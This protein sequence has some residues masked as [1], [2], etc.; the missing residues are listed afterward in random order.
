MILGLIIFVIFGQ[1]LAHVGSRITKKAVEKVSEV[2]A[3]STS[4]NR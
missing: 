2:A 3:K 4:H 1:W